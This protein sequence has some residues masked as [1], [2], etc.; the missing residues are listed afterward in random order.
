MSF[1]TLYFG[2]LWFLPDIVDLNKYKTDFATAIEE[3]SGFKFSCEDI[4]LSRSLSPYLNVKMHHTLILYP[5][6]EVFLKLKD[7]EL[8][9]K[10]FPLL[11]KKVVVKDAKLTRPIINV[12]LYKDFSTSIEK[13]YDA[14]KTINTKGFSIDAV[15]KDTI[16]ER[17]KLKINDEIT[18]KLFYLEGDELLLKDIKINDKIH[19]ILKGALFE[20]EKEYL[21]YNLDITSPLQLEKSKFTFS[22]FKTIYD[23]DISGEVLGKLVVDKNKEIDGFLN[24]N[25]ISLKADDIVLDDNSINL[26]FKGQEAQIKSV[27]HTSKTDIA[28]VSGKFAYGKKKNIDLTAKARNIDL[29]NLLK[30]ITVISQTLNIPNQLKDISVTGLV[31]AD[32][33]VNSDFKKLKSSGVAKVINAKVAHNSLPYIISDVNANINLDNN[34]IFIEQANALV[35]STPINITGKINEDVSYL[36]NVSSEH[37]NLKKLLGLFKINI[38]V[39]IKA[40][41]LSLKSE[42]FGYLNK[43]LN[44]KADVLVSDL[45]FVEKTLNIPVDIK[46]TKVNVDTDAKKYKGNIIISDFSSKYDNVPVNAKTLNLSFDEKK[47]IILDNNLILKKSPIKI[48]GIINEYLK[49]PNVV[50]GFDGKLYAS[51]LSDILTKYINQPHSAKGELETSGKL[52]ILNNS[53]DLKMNIEADSQ[54]YLSYVVIKELLNKPSIFSLN[55]SLKDKI[56]NVEKFSL[57]ENSEEIK[58]DIL[59]LTGEIKLDKETKFNDVKVTIPNPIS[60]STNFFGGEDV[61]LSANLN[62]NDSIK[63]PILRGNAKI[64]SYNIKKYLTAIK[65]ADI[66][67][68]PN[69]IRIIAPDVQINNSKVNVYADINNQIKDKL[70]LSNVQLMCANLDMNSLFALIEKEANPF[71]KSLIDIKNGVAIINNFSILDLK[72][73]DISADFS[74]NDNVLKLNNI[75]ANAYNGQVSG[76]LDYDIPHSNLHLAL[77]GKHIDMKNS[78][79]DLCKLDDNI[80]GIADFDTDVSMVT[81]D[82]KTVLNSLKG[83]L[84]FKSTNGKMGTLGKFEYYLYAQN[85]L[86]HG[87]LKT[88]LNRIADVFKKGGDTAQYRTANGTISFENGYMNTQAIKTIGNDMSLFVKGRHNLISNQ[89]NIDIYGR[90]SD[91]ITSQLGSF[92]NVSIS[93]L[94]ESKSQKTTNNLIFV[95]KNVIDE[96]PLLYNQGTSKTNT[97]KV[98]LLG[99]INSLSAIN[100]FMWILP[101]ENSAPETE[102]LPEFLD[103]IKTL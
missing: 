18:G 76:S 90:I 9:V 101:Q 29:K 35:N 25:N 94:L 102:K 93:D 68:E 98:N 41:S 75:S 67:F 24:V 66:S 78:L 30:I 8:K 20:S 64:F 11:F 42:L 15:V 33:S 63:T 39:E 81:G 12:T 92:G 58:N 52:T 86:Y 70:E 10:L 5:N 36:L 82:D 32:F 56:L 40:G 89:V 53:A 54:N 88:T 13:Y 55:C 95:P 19:L 3:Q 73:R 14:S 87:L 47:I 57:K 72:A 4:K 21:K 50:L 83:T 28:E 27:L 23:S 59:S 48:S 31:D 69:N 7:S 62:L 49:K 1:T 96:I 79:Y 84:D 2:A 46:E 65:N 17:Y 71:A 97:F 44:L 99:D 103:M 85:I 51:D 61:S 100:S 91:E 60:F 22:P 26:I 80:A 16:C 45:S 74:L 37:L 77:N 6:D 43:N 34:N 38:P